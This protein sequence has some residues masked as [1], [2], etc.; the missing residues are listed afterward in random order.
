MRLVTWNCNLSLSRKLPRI[1][2]LAP[3]VAIVQECERDVLGLP[4]DAHY[5]WI[6]NNPRKGL[7]VISFGSPVGLVPLHR[8]TWAYFLPL[9]LPAFG[10][11]LLATWAYNHRASRFGPEHNGML[12][13][14][15]DQL[16]DWLSVG[17]TI[18]AGDFN[19]SVVWD[20]QH[21]P[22]NFSDVDAALHKLGLRSAYHDGT[23][24][25]LGSESQSTYFHTKNADKPFH[26]DYVYAHRSIP[27]THTR[28]LEFADWRAESDHVPVVIETGDF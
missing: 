16:Q 1:V 26:I 11:K 3:D 14:V 19:N 18:V 27:I 22:N 23:G 17:P 9:H 7:G 20:R 13:T 25:N 4:K 10:L 8:D 2:A 12:L 6:G 28:V 15:L 5:Q 24:E 21:G